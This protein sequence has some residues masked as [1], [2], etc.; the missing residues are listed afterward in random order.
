MHEEEQ[1]TLNL[2]LSAAME[3]FLKKGFR[4]ASL[5]IS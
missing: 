2:L 4:G 3:E 5:D 1:N